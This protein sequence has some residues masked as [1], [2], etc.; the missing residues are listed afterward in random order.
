MTSAGQAPH[1]LIESCQGLVRSLALKIHRNLP[2]NVNLDDLIGYG[3]VGLAEAARD[4]DPD[5]GGQFA[6][7]AYYRIRGSIYDGLA[8]M[9]WHKRDYFRRLKAEQMSNDVLRLCSEDDPASNVRTLEQE[10]HWLK[11]VARTLSVVYLTTWAGSD[12]KES[13]LEDL[14]QPTP[15]AIV[16]DR[17]VQQK[18]RALI[19]ELPED[20]R[21]LIQG[22]YF[23]GMTITAAGE[24][25]GISKAWASRL[26]AKM[27]DR[28][29][30]SLRLAGVDRA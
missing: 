4:Y 3:Q 13:E 22:I 11:N 19:E 12:E 20:A 9:S 18:L 1:G 16:G 15:E 5:R 14:S 2:G 21:S 25:A 24:R 29:G 7:F 30:R 8:K 27:L 28:I 10:V 17:E 23:E 26:H 6:T